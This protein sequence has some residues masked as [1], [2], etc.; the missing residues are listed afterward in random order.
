M[1]SRPVEPKVFV[2]DDDADVR[3]ALK[4]LIESV[5]LQAELFASAEEF[6]DGYAQELAGCVVLDVRMPGM[7]GL[8]LLERLQ[9]R[10][11]HLPIIIL[12]GHGDVPLAVRALKAGA[13]DFIEKPFAGQPMVERI[14]KALEIGQEQRKNALEINEIAARMALLTAREREV[15]SLVVDGKANKTISAELG[16]SEKTVETHRKNLMEKLRARSLADLVHMS[17]RVR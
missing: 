6:L 7:G 3:K 9:E 15:L 12:T 1:D 11:C 17:L 8:A 16:I 13:F 4:W 10:G 2:V 5:N 14:Q